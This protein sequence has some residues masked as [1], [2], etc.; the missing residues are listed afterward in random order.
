MAKS[1]GTLKD[2]CVFLA[3]PASTALGFIVITAHWLRTAS[4]LFG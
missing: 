4:P 1:L 3:S 2:E